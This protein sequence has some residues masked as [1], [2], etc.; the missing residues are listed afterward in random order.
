M[1]GHCLR[2]CLAIAASP[3]P[4]DRS[5]PDRSPAPPLLAGTMAAN[6]VTPYEVAVLVQAYLQQGGFN[7]TA[8]SFKR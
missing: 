7:K 5:P 2:R 3:P 4:T 1:L 6:T 8:A